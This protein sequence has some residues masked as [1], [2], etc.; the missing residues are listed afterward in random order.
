MA[1]SQTLLDLIDRFTPELKKAFLAAIQDIKDS[2]RLGQI[3]AAI[4]AGSMQSAIDAIGIDKAAFR[5]LTAAMEQAFE[6]GGV[7]TASNFTRQAGQAAFR[8]DV[9]NSRA[10]AWLRD[11][12]ST[13]VQGIQD[14]QL[15]LVRSVL[16]KGMNTGVNPK[17]LASNIVGKVGP[18]GREG[19]ILGLN[20]KQLE[21]R[22]NAID[23]LRNMHRGPYTDP[24]TGRRVDPLAQYKNRELRDKRFDS[25][26][27]KAE[28]TGTPL[29]SDDISRLGTRYEDGLLKW[30][31]ETIARDQSITA[32]NQSQNEAA[33]Q[34]IESGAADP[35]DVTREWDSAGDSRT[36][37]S[38]KEM[39][40]QQRRVN[41]PFKA[42]SGA[43][44]MYP[45]DTS[46]NAPASET[47]NCR[48]VVKLTVDYIGRAK[49]LSA[50][51]PTNV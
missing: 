7:F 24:V 23:E 36:R 5:P 50:V 29:S 6:T 25:L 41:E 49:R 17:T 37:E 43:L 22:D 20:S 40:G 38:H 46:L 27:E 45:G 12:S 30:R 16:N 19:G 44:M 8:F 32:L 47:I 28:R 51:P 1:K 3:E 48:C 13:L 9:R 21:Y 11:Q 15:E 26:V 34:L 18:N 31:G 39:D 10:E 2:A 33:N 42:P 35:Q 14:E 4:R